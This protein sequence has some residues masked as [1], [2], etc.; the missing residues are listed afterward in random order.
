MDVSGKILDIMFDRLPM[1][2]HVDL[3]IETPEV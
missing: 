1:G 3:V 2:S